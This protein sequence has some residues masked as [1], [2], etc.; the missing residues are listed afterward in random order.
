[1]AKNTLILLGFLAVLALLVTLVIKPRSLDEGPAGGRSGPLVA[2]LEKGK[3]DKIE[4][5][6]GGETTVVERKEGIWIVSSQN[7]FPADENAVNRALDGLAKLRDLRPVSRNPEKHE[8]FEV[9]GEKAVEVKIHAGGG[10]AAHFFL[11]KVAF[12]SGSSYLRLADSDEVYEIS[13]KLHDD[14]DRGTK[15][16][17]TSPTW[18]DRTLSRIKPEEVARITIKKPQADK[19]AEKELIVETMENGEAMIKKP[20]EARAD[21][22]KWLAVKNQLGHIVAAG[23]VEDETDPAT[24]GF[25]KPSLVIDIDLKDGTRK[26]L[27][28]GAKSDKNRYYAKRGEIGA[29]YEIMEYVVKNL[30]KTAEDLRDLSPASPQSE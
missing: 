16:T 29:V 28:F 18:K 11:G 24:L 26:T 19:E 1:M 27:I 13:R 9:A 20:F 8:L 4:V 30:S 12:A 6:S 2:G 15:Y 22:N 10:L 25:D 7:D 14:F 17:P 3:V 21:P 23:F 5:I